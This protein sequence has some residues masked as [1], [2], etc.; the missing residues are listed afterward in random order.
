PT[1]PSASKSGQLA[2]QGPEE[3]LSFALPLPLPRGP[4]TPVLASIGS[5][6]GRAASPAV[7]PPTMLSGTS[8]TH[9]TTMAAP[10]VAA[11]HAVHPNDRMNTS[12]NLGLETHPRRLTHVNP[13]LRPPVLRVAAFWD[14][15]SS[16]RGGNADDSRN[17]RKNQTQT[18]PLW[19][20]ASA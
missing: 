20:R 9:P 7:L 17:W 15:R 10:I 16:S 19:W 14:W 1:T 6:S 5:V 2:S 12:V 13:S 8:D 18:V 4:L 11:S 3:P